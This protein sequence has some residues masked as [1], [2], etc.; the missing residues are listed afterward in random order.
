MRRRLANRHAGR[1]ALAATAIAA[2]VLVALCVSVDLVA[3]HNLR[4]Q[5]ADRLE[6]YV[7]MLAAE[8]SQVPS[9]E[10]DFDDPV[11]AWRV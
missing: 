10:P 7:S 3:N 4:A 11:V 5:A 1:T 8:S 6:T 9:I 2:V